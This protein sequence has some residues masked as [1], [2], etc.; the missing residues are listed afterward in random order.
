[1]RPE[2]P[3]RA[4]WASTLIAFCLHFFNPRNLRL[5]RHRYAYAGDASIS[6]DLRSGTGDRSAVGSLAR[7]SRRKHQ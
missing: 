4:Y 7:R 6:P 2:C 5:M 1:V 3:D